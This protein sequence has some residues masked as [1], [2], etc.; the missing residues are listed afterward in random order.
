[1]FE[2]SDREFE[3]LWPGFLTSHM[4]SAVAAPEWPI[5]LKPFGVAMAACLMAYNG[6]S[7][8]SFVAGEVKHPQRNVLRSLVL[9]MTAVA[10]LYILAN[11]A[12]LRVMTVPEIAASDRVGADAATLA[13]GSIGGSF[14]SATVLLS[15]V[16]AVNGCILTAARLPFAEARDGL[17]FAHF[18]EVHPRFQTPATGIV[19]G[20]IWTAIL[21]LTYETLYS[22]AIGAAWIFYTMTVAAVFILR[23]QMPDTARPYTMWGYPYTLWS[24][25]VVSVGFIVNAFITQPQSSLMALVV[26]ATGIGAYFAWRKLHPGGERA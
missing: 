4:T 10:A 5:T 11:A 13:M 17:F 16:G 24:F 19:W 8:V 1:M 22:Y 7:Y 12:Y 23:R 21:V 15:I 9:G 25:V 14:I 2:L 20:G 3:E 6:W 26:I 18:A